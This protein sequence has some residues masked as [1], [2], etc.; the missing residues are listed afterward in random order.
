MKNKWYVATLLLRCKVGD[1]DV[2]PWACDEQ[3]HVLRAHDEDEAFDKALKLGQE[4]EHS[5]KNA[6]GEVVSWSFIGLENLEELSS[7]S[8]RDGT[9]IKSR[10]FEESN[11]S[12]LVRQKDGL[13]A[14]Q[15][16]RNKHRTAEE[17]ISE[18]E[19]SDGT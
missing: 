14:Y 6:Y 19:L 7:P 16:Q 17:I 8:I 15:A 18:H 9:E 1:G 4:E 5:Y 3:V 13:T 10:I 2:G 11:P 12:R